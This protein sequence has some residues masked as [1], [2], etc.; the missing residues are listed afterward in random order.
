MAD[1]Q[2]LSGWLG[3]PE[4]QKW[5]GDPI[6]QAAI[7]KNDIIDSRMAMA[8]RMVEYHTKPFAYIQDYEVHAWPQKHLRHL[9]SGT[10][11]IDTFIGEPAMLGVGHGPAYLRQRALQLLD[12]GSRQ[13]V[14][15]PDIH[16]AHAISAYNKAGFNQHIEAQADDGAVLLMTFTG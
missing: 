14:I 2:L 7:L 4:V 11:A 6:E 12:N 5:W 16:N 15:D 13:I 3:N 1:F 8:M 9:A 10:R